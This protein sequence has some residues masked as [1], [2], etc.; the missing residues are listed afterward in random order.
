MMDEQH[1]RTREGYIAALASGLIWGLLPLYIRLLAGLSPLWFVAQRVFWSLLFVGIIIAWRREI[2]SFIALLR[3]RTVVVPIAISAILIAANW[4]TYVFAVSLHHVLA[5]SLGYFLNPLV[6]VMLGVVFLGERLNRAQWVAVIIAFSGAALLAFSALDTLWISLVL[7]LT[8]ALYGF[9]RKTAPIEALPGLT[10]ETLMLA[11]LALACIMLIDPWTA[12]AQPST[13]V[14]WL[15]PLSGMITS[16]PL[17]L[18]S[19][20]AR[21]LTLTALGLLQYIAPSLQFLAGLVVF[22]EPFSGAKLASFLIVWA[23]LVVFTWDSVRRAHRR[24]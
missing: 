16:V 8:F 6:S 18:F 21:R 5:A 9:V 2:S 13:L 24:A 23:G 15:L 3:T 14:Y 10:M 4:T 7:A 22:G 11:P 12:G 20:S 1:Q 19:Y 17:L